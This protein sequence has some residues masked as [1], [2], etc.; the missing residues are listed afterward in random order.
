MVALTAPVTGASAQSGGPEVVFKAGGLTYDRGGDATRLMVGMGIDW[1]ISR[2]I[3][4][5]VGTTYSDAKFSFTEFSGG[6]VRTAEGKAHLLTASTGIQAQAFLGPLRPYIGV[7]TG[8]FV[9][10]DPEG[11]DRFARPMHAFPFGV[12]A[13]VSR[14]VGVRGEIRLRFDEH[15]SGSSA[16][17]A[18]QTLGVSI[19][20]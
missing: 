19:R 17:D 1:E 20:F 4:A 18:E 5:E 7:G 8:V 3:L 6:S 11:G 15:Q 2:H 14:R 13:Q 16:L 12:R 10:L 9:R